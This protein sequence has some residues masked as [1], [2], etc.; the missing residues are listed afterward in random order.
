[1]KRRAHI[2][3]FLL[4]LLTSAGMH[5]QSWPSWA[6][7]NLLNHD[8]VRA[9]NCHT[10]A[11]TL[12]LNNYMAQTAF[13]GCATIETMG[14]NVQLSFSTY[15]LYPSW[16][17][18]TV[19]D[20]DSATGTLLVHHTTTTQSTSYYTASSGMMTIRLQINPLTVDRF[21]SFNFFWQ[22]SA[23]ETSAFCPY[24]IDGLSVSNISSSEATVAWNTTAPYCVVEMGDRRWVTPNQSLPIDSLEANTEYS[25]TVTPVQNPSA[26]S[27]PCCAI[28]TSFYTDMMACIGC[29]DIT[30]LYADYV[31]CYYGTYDDPYANVGRVYDPLIPIQTYNRHTV[32]SNT[33]LTDFRTGHQLYQVCPGTIAS[34]RLGNHNTGAEAESI[35]YKLHIDTLFYSLLLLRYAVVLENPNHPSYEQPRFTLEILDNNNNLIDPLCGAA[36]FVA[37]HTTGWNRTGIVE[38]KDWTTVGFDLTSYH[39]QDVYVRF[40]T[41]D[42]AAGGHFGYAY[43]S[44]ECRHRS[45]TAEHCGP[46]EV[47]TITA[48]EGFLYRWYS[49]NPNNIISTERSITYTSTDNYYHCQLVSTE[50]PACYVT[51]HAY[52]GNRYPLAIPDTF[53]CEDLGCDGY[54]VIFLNRSTVSGANGQVLDYHENCETAY[55]NFG[56][57]VTSHTYSPEHIY[58]RSGT[59]TVSLAAGI[60]NDQCLDTATLTLTIPDFYIPTDSLVTACDSLL[61]NGNEVYWRDTVGPIMHTQHHNHCDTAY[62]LHLTI[63]ESE[64]TILP[65]D[66]FCYNSSYTWYGQTIGPRSADFT[67]TARHRLV[68]NIPTGAIC[69][70]LVIL[71]LVQLPPDTVRILWVSD[72][73]E[74]SYSLTAITDMPYLHW[75]SSPYDP[76]LVSQEHGN[77]LLVAPQQTTYYTVTVDRS[78]T[79]YCPTTR[80]ITLQPVTFPRAKLRVQPEILVND[81]R[82]FSAYDI[83]RRYD[84]RYWGIVNH[85]TSSDTLWLPDSSSAIYHTLGAEYD[86][87]TVLL[88]VSNDICLDTAKGLVRIIH[89]NIYAPNV[90][91]PGEADNNRFAIMGEGILEGVL[92]IYNRQ[93]LLVYT[94]DKPCEGWDGTHRGSP[95]SQGAYVWHLR[96]RSVHWPDAWNVATGTVTLLR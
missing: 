4:L 1:M 61:W 73:R 35:V 55:W 36:N 12:Q 5:A 62:T 84:I 34:V 94:T 29:P 31:R 58:R 8:T 53:F 48:P 52:L 46:V 92:T 38:W 57:G 41:Y 25:V 3:L 77:P 75:N 56:D 88:I 15:G 45:V 21:M 59:L 42:C 16:G 7:Q 66:T 23:D 22:A 78:D 54:R 37:G 40:T 93:G 47:N 28:S 30:N 43:F 50:N 17:S 19:W 91:T 18:I 27:F 68:R 69:D 24:S 96:Y 39:G 80:G 11:G 14:G 49:D 95:C 89:T 51:M 63:L 13:N 70:S 72:C 83:S 44:T 82:D 87:A 81:Q 86:S 10:Q 26:T 9:Y 71:P 67:D 74:K 32:I 6:I 90:F 60:G 33:S 79:G 20:G 85:G 64:K 76:D 2:T 65:A